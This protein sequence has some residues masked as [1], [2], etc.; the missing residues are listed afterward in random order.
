MV[1]G[2]LPITGSKTQVPYMLDVHMEER[3]LCYVAYTRAKNRLICS[4]FEGDRCVDVCIL[5]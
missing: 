5:Y 4:Y 1:Q 2:V 3:R